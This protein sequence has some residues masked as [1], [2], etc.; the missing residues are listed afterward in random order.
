MRILMINSGVIGSTGNIMLDLAATA[1]GAGHE[2][3]TACP[4]G[5]SM[6]R[7]GL[8]DHIYI[9]NRLTRN[10]HLLLGKVTGYHGIFS[11]LSTAVFLHKVKCFKPD[12]IHLHNLHDCYI[13]LPIL[14][15]YLK[16]HD[17]KVIWTLHDCWSFTGG[18]PHFVL[19]KCDKWKTGCGTCPSYKNYPASCV[20]RSNGMWQLKKKWFT[21]VNN[22]TL[23]TP[24]EWLARLV[25]QS[26]LKEY[27]VEVINN[28][29]DLNVFKPTPSDLRT[30]ILGVNT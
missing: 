11:V 15:R 21:G 20:D 30:K 14:F 26:F 17:V 27:P 25:R 1:R 28:G 16:K 13:N 8:N 2:C 29:I 7:E 5:K 3:I 19:K 9:G 22:L 18:C 24:S 6:R 12:V 4:A 10:V 23:V